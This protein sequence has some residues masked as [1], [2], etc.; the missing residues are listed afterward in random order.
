M[1]SKPDKA[2]TSTW[3]EGWQ[4]EADSFT[5]KARKVSGYGNT[6]YLLRWDIHIGGNGYMNNKIRGLVESLPKKQL[7]PD[8]FPDPKRSEVCTL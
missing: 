4:S 5:S 8:L 7:L 6:R 3:T 2:E 1:F